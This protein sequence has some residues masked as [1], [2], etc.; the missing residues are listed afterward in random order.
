MRVEFFLLS[1]DINSIDT[2][3]EPTTH[4]RSIY[5]IKKK[6][7]PAVSSPQRH[8]LISMQ[9]SVQL[10]YLWWNLSF[11]L[12]LTHEIISRSLLMLVSCITCTPKIICDNVESSEMV[13]TIH[14]NI[15]TQTH[16]ENSNFWRRE[17]R[18][19]EYG[20]K[21]WCM[22]RNRKFANKFARKWLKCLMLR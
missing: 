11:I 15:L 9:R 19:I 12:N 1:F 20:V 3:T 6:K 16:L 14:N 4:Q 2:G 8:N 7:T 10:C 21:R 22:Y 13:Q 17:H 18:A 5:F